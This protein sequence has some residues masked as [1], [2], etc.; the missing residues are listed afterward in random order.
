M[1]SASVWSKRIRNPP[2]RYKP[3]NDGP[4]LDDFKEEEYDTDDDGSS[5]SVV[6]VRVK[7]KRPIQVTMIL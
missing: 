7:V 2:D 4:F 5:A 1:K 3:E 6:I